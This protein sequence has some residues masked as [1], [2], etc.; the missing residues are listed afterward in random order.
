MA[1]VRERF[2]DAARPCNWPD[3]KHPATPVEPA[4]DKKGDKKDEKD[5]KG[6]A[7]STVLWV[8]RD[9]RAETPGQP[10]IINTWGLSMGDNV[11]QNL[12]KE[13]VTLDATDENGWTTLMWSARLNQAQAV[14][15]LVR[16]GALVGLRSTKDVWRFAAGSSAAEIA[17]T[18]QGYDDTDRAAILSELRAAKI[19]QDR[20]AQ[21]QAAYDQASSAA[22]S[23]VVEAE[24]SAA[25]SLATASDTSE[26]H[27][28]AQVRLRHRVREAEQERGKAVAKA[29]ALQK[30]VDVAEAKVVQ[31]EAAMAKLRQEHQAEIEKIR[32][33][34][35]ETQSKLREHDLIQALGVVGPVVAS[36]KE[37][38]P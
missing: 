26:A 30:R 9:R 15:E 24:A 27:V 4:K 5:K 2:D 23:R 13:S 32:L 29:K 17:A 18:A 7:P 33:E 10:S 6:P 22:Q 28:E 21:L 3:S 34:H 8:S 1:S 25:S 12:Q 19:T 16:G 11:V 14:R 35:A 38:L 37:S 31:L 20:Q 36:I